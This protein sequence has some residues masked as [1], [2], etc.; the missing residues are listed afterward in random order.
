MI[1][2]ICDKCA[3][4]VLGLHTEFDTEEVRDT[5][6]ILSRL[7]DRGKYE[8]CNKCYEQYKRLGISISEYMKK[9]LNELNLLDSTF[10]VGDE[11][12]TADGRVGVVKS[13]CDCERC[14]E[15][16]FYEPEVE[17]T[18]GHDTIW[19]TDY[20]KG[21]GFKRFYKIGDKLF[22][23]IDEDA[24]YNLRDCINKCKKE[25][26]DSEAQLEMLN[27]IKRQRKLLEVLSN[28]DC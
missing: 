14:R 21:N 7:L 28:D 3:E 27:K 23:N 24:S 12:I 4:E 10:K 19:I 15:R 16:G 6:G 26:S 1:K 20:D 9:P 13:I 17:L 11:V 22:G 2:L 18:I 8:L 5:H 25:I